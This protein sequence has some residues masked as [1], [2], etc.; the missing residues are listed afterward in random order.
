M[1]STTPTPLTLTFPKE[2]GYVLLTAAS[3]FFLSFWHGARIGFFRKAAGIVYPQHYAE[4]A[5]LSAASAEQKKAMYLYNCAQR[6]HGMYMIFSNMRG[7][8][9]IGRE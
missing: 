7:R 5:D 1:A 9:R 4:K 6:A 3:T 8:E 2:Y